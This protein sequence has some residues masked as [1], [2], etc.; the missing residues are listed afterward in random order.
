MYSQKDTVCCVLTFLAQCV[1]KSNAVWS[2]LLIFFV[3][4]FIF[5]F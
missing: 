2:R 4:L 5:F 3:C 1:V